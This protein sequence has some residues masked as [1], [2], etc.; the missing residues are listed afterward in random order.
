MDSSPQ[1]HA[2]QRAGHERLKTVG[3]C[4]TIALVVVAKDRAWSQLTLKTAPEVLTFFN[5][6]TY[7]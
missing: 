5:A 3:V 6:S 2:V 4:I 7:F 1:A